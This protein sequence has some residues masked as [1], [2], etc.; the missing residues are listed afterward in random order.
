[1][2]APDNMADTEDFL[3]SMKNR[4]R[5][6]IVAGLEGGAPKSF[7]I[8]IA[9]GHPRSCAKTKRCKNAPSM[10]KEPVGR[11]MKFGSGTAMPDVPEWYCLVLSGR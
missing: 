8:R 9:P 2:K 3:V 1:M 5:A 6:M 4:G 7:C 10:K 11:G